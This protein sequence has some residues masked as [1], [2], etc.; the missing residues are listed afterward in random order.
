[1]H[2]LVNNCLYKLV[3]SPMDKFDVG[4]KMRYEKCRTGRRGREVPLSTNRSSVLEGQRGALNGDVVTH[5]SGRV[6][7]DAIGDDRE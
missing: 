2:G 6:P 5:V 4:T 1:M 3:A 7:Q